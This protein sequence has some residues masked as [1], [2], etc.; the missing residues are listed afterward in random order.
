MGHVAHRHGVLLLDVGEQGPLVVD[1]EV[2][3]AVLVGQLEGGRVGG[4]GRGRVG[5]VR[6]KG[7]AVEGREHGELELEGVG[8]GEGERRPG[9]PGVFGEGDGVFLGWGGG[10]G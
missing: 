10:Q 6:G 2:E 4:L 3:D 9:G 1:L 8:G 5:R 7:Q